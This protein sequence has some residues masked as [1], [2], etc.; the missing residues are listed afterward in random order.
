M[1]NMAKAIRTIKRRLGILYF[2]LPIPDEDLIEVLE[3]DTLGVFSTYYPLYVPYV[4]NLNKCKIDDRNNIYK[5]DTRMLGEGMDIIT[6]EDINYDAYRSGLPV[7]YTTDVFDY[8]TITAGMNLQAVMNNPITWDFIYP[9]KLKID[10]E[11][12]GYVDGE[13]ILSLGVKHNKSLAS[14]P[15]GLEETFYRLALLDVQIFLYNNLKHFTGIDTTFGQIDLKID[16][17]SSADDDR[18][19]L[20]NEWET[21]YLYNRKRR[22]YN[23]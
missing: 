21:E 1:L 17:W 7:G 6:V 22:I 15:P 10:D 11:L 5:I 19:N 8:S 16:E 14:I 23:A 2:K 9:D 18:I 13:V 12:S 20:I 3:D 4:M